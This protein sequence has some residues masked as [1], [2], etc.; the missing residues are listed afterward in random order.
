MANERCGAMEAAAKM[1]TALELSRPFIEASYLKDQYSIFVSVASEKKALDAIDAALSAAA[2]P[3][4]C[5]D[6]QEALMKVAEEIGLQSASAALYLDVRKAIAAAALSAPPSAQGVPGA[7][8]LVPMEPTPAMLKAGWLVEPGEDRTAKARYAAILAACAPA[9]TPKGAMDAAAIK[10]AYGEWHVS[11]GGP[12][13]GG[14]EPYSASDAFEGGYRLAAARAAA[15]PCE[16]GGLREALVDLREII[17][18]RADDRALNGK[19][20]ARIDAALG[21]R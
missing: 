10:R 5:A 18:A 7:M 19:L 1:K 15:A 20:V 14:H 17:A 13:H 6:A 16:C 3:C 9:A 2:A 12:G 4:A 11:W 21:E 8:V